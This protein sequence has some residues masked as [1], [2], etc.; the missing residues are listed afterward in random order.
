MP[1]EI[2]KVT[3][4]G[5]EFEQIVIEKDFL[6]EAEKQR[7]AEIGAIPGIYADGTVVRSDGTIIRPSVS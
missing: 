5:A 3:K 6:S 7:V 4:A 2:I 1:T